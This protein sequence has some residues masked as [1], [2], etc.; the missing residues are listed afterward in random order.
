MVGTG[1][2]AA[3]VS[4]GT[5]I[6]WTAPSYDELRR[7]HRWQI[8]A[9]LNIAALACDAHAASGKVGLIEIDEAGA[10]RELTFRELSDSSGRLAG[11]LRSLGVARGDRVAVFLPQRSE[12]A[13]A[14]LAAFKLGAVSVPLSPLFRAEALGH[15]LGSSGARVIVTDTEH[16]PAVEQLGLGLT[17]LC[18]E[19]LPTLIAE[20]EPLPCADTAS[21]DPAMLIYT[22]GTTGPARGALHAHRFLPGRLPGFELI[23]RLVSGPER[24]RPFW[25]PADWAW[26]GGLVDSVLTPWVFG[27][28]VL[29][30]RRGRFDPERAAELIASERV[31]SLFLPPTAL[32][33]LRAALPELRL[34]VFSVHTAGE[35]LPAETYAWAAGAFGTVYEL[36]GMTEMGAT[37]GSSPLS[38]VKPGSMGRP[39]PG[40][41]VALLDARGEPVL[42]PGEGEI[43]VRRGDPGMF[44]GYLGDPEATRARFRGEWLVTG[45][46][47]R[48]DADGYYTH[49]GR[50]DDVFNASGY[51]IGPTEIEDALLLHPDVAEA[52]VVGEPDAE[53]GHL[54]K[55]FVVPRPGARPDAEEIQRFVRER[56]AAYE[57]PRKIVFCRELP[58]TETGKIRRGEL[59]APGAD[60]RFGLPLVAR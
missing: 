24:D 32:H 10:R 42:G 53:R 30:W 1:A 12:C 3:M 37:I 21:D 22:S 51:R 35:P 14:H 56:L 9:R 45:D 55:A 27:F 26:V 43:A 6:D 7:R 36:Y 33:R 44:L 28:P 57:S 52:A 2:V 41:E 11:L 59:R 16:R 25:T 17:I 5:G 38:P 46:V 34:P 54:I 50:N 58:R 13:L 15:R 39:F 40:H 29:A 47:A 31:R 4:T 18:A 8:P 23:H 20:Q 60:E 19:A 49:L 48:R